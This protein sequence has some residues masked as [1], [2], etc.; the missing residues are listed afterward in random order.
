MNDLSRPKGEGEAMNTHIAPARA[1][2]VLRITIGVDPGISG[3]LVVLADGEPV[4]F[5][6]MPTYARASGGNEVDPFRM[7]A[8][9]RGI[10]QQHSGAFISAALEPPSTRPGESPTRGQ[11]SGESYGIVKGV[12]GAHGIRW[13]E[14]RPQ[15]WKKYFGLIGT[16]K[17]DARLYAIKRHPAAM[18]C[19][20]RKKDN[21]RADALLIARWAWETES[22]ETNAGTR[23]A[24]DMFKGVAA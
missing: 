14:V 24:P 22:F 10:V 9:V 3:A 21:G 1:E 12:L 13:C 20:A 11:R 6:D 23:V 15:T 16:E 5:I 4:Q 8:I 19:M 7:S 18:S 17:D 2:S